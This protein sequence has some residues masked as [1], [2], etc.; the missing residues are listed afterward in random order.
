[1]FF[2]AC[3]RVAQARDAI[4]RSGRYFVFDEFSDFLGSSLP[5]G[6]SLRK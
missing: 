5:P 2:N 1:M 6:L 4:L 3:L